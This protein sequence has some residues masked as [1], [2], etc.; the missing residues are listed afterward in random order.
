[1]FL[2]R[3]LGSEL[4]KSTIGKGR[5]WLGRVGLGLGRIAVTNADSDLG[6][7]MNFLVAGCR[8]RLLFF[9]WQLNRQ[10]ESES[11]SVMLG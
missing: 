10:L 1:M 6:F 7:S 11:A 5:L 4:A 2:N 9:N 8:F 3:Q